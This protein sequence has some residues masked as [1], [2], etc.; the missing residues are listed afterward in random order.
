MTERMKSSVSSSSSVAIE[1][2][3]HKEL[4]I[5]NFQIALKLLPHPFGLTFLQKLFPFPHLDRLRNCPRAIIS[6][7]EFLFHPVRDFFLLRVRG[8]VK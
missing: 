2:A 1:S 4:L 8:F 6:K 3:V 5:L 7:V